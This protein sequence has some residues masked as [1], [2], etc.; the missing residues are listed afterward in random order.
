M[1]QEI[2]L[3]QLMW[4][5]ESLVPDDDTDPFV[6]SLT[7]QRTDTLSTLHQRQHARAPTADAAIQLRLV[8]SQLLYELTSM[9]PPNTAS[10]TYSWQNSLHIADLPA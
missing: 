4:A 6:L 3:L 8:L 10:A 1:A 9:P 5:V 7:M 2:E